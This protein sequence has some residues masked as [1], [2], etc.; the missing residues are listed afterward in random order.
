MRRTFKS[1]IGIIFILLLAVHLFVITVIM[2]P[3]QKVISAFMRHDIE[4]IALSEIPEHVQ[5]VFKVDSSYNF[6][7][8]EKGSYYDIV[9]AK[10]MNLRINKF[11][12]DNERLEFY[13]NTLSFGDKLTGLQA[14][15]EY[16]FQKPVS[17]LSFE[18]ALTLSGIYKIFK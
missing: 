6:N 4:Y 7:L 8:P 13:L 9:L 2:C 16:Y 11:F 10:I 12:N 15:S 18:E 14:A 3:T 17:E 1:I 5:Q